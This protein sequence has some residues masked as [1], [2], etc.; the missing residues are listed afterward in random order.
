MDAAPVRKKH[1]ETPGPHRDNSPKEDRQPT[2]DEERE[3]G[4]R[5]EREGG[6]REGRRE[7]EERGREGQGIPT[8]SRIQCYPQRPVRSQVTTGA[9]LCVGKPTGTRWT[10]GAET[11]GHSEPPSIRRTAIAL[12]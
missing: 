10:C 8:P 12:D 9:P 11:E 3:E 4:K 1:E 2:R 7:E 6:R 5:G